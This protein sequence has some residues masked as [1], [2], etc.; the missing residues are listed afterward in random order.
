MAFSDFLPYILALA[1]AVPF[2]LL[3]R[4]F[5]YTY[6]RMKEKELKLLSLKS[7]GEN[8][9]QAYER[10][11]LF[12][13]RL[14]PSHLVKNFDENLKPHEFVFL[15]EKN[16]SE[17]FAYNAAQQIYLSKSAWQSVFQ[18]KEEV[19]KLLHGTYEG[20]G[21]KAELS[22]FK[23]VFLMAY[24]EGEDYISQTIEMLRREALLLS[25]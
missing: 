7:G 25:N 22:D 15:I 6:I 1:I 14:K 5:V 3:L 16:I 18:A 8:T 21:E 17:E 10:M 20:L 23:T 2:L 24:L 11:T 13:E 12:L 19:L 4:Q 9:L